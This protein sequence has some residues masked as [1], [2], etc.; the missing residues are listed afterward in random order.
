[1]F[2]SE[3]DNREKFE[4]VVRNRLEFFRGIAR[5]ILRNQAD[6]DDAV[7][8]ALLKSWE[9]CCFIRNPQSMAGWIG[10]IVVN[11]SYNIIRDRRK[12]ET[13]DIENAGAAASPDNDSEADYQRMEEAIAS[14]PEKYRQTIHIAVLSGLE[15]DVAAEMLECS[16]ETLYTR[17]HRAKK[18]LRE[19]LK[20]E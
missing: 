13:V 18:L 15:T 3:T 2:F 7:Q 9:K 17:I 8:N 19:A 11:E 10:R 14:L 4:E 1:M 16:P 12:M 20:D 5:R 6:A